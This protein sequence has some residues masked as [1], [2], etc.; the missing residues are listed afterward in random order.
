MTFS[1]FILLIFILSFQTVLAVDFFKNE[2][3]G[4]DYFPEKEKENKEDQEED[5]GFVYKE[6]PVVTPKTQK[7]TPVIIDKIKIDPR[8]VYLHQYRNSIWAKKMIG[9]DGKVYVTLPDEESIRAAEATTEEERKYWSRKY[10]A[11]NVEKLTK[12]GKMNQTVKA[13]SISDGFVTPE[14]FS[15]KKSIPIDEMKLDQF[16][17]ASLKENSL[18]DLKNNVPV[19]GDVDENKIQVL[20]FYRGT[21]PSCLQILPDI[22]KFTT[23]YKSHIQVKG[24]Y[25]RPLDEYMEFLRYYYDYMQEPLP[26]KNW[27]L[28]QLNKLNKFNYASKLGISGANNVVSTPTIVFLNLK[29][30][31][32]IV[33][34]GSQ[35]KLNVLERTLNE[36]L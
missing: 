15:I 19:P 26:F 34:V 22:N 17:N 31:K 18:I 7:K 5:S 4:I 12:W 1:K 6:E 23:K 36:I 24:V 29:T 3:D 11:K 2:K 30:K 33:L 9:P 8:D 27:N 25:T 35:N 20:F 32:K 10:L 14:S 28:I 16:S 21:C 13:V